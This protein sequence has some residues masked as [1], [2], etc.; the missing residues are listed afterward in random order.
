MGHKF[1]LCMQLLEVKCVFDQICR[2]L[3]N[4]GKEKL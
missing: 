1:E 4:Y 2:I 3:L